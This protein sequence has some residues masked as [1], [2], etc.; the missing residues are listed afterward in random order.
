M[1][2]K[3]KIKQDKII[4]M[5]SGFCEEKLDEEYKELC[6]KLVEKLGRKHDVPFRRG[7]LENWASG[8]VYTIGQLNF[9]FDDSFEPY[10]TADDICDYF[11]TKKS[12]AA[13]KARDIRKLLNLKLGNEEFST[14]LIKEFDYTGIG[15]DLTQIKTLDNAIRISNLRNLRITSRKSEINDNIVE[16]IENNELRELIRE[17]FDSEGDYISEAHLNKLYKILPTSFLISPACGAGILY[18]G[19]TRGG[20]SIPAFTS[21]NEYNLSF[22][23]AEIN[24]VVWPF[25][26]VL[27]YLED[28]PELEGVVINPHIDNFFVSKDM[29]Q[30]IFTKILEM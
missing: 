24:P 22:E 17:I 18:I 13:N 1:D 9:L 4:E 11:K 10:A 15:N 30:D 23:G 28:E 26:F 29:I 5:V 12:T 6:V 19:D 3:T 20:V 14:E 7:K 16:K 27:S 8:V 25:G 2:E 21:M